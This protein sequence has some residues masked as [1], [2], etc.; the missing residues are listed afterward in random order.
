MRN[1]IDVVDNANRAVFGN[2]LDP[3]GVENGQDGIESGGVRA[4]STLPPFQSL[5]GCPVQAR[6]LGKVFGGPTQKRTCRT[7]LGRSNHTVYQYV[8]I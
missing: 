7:N 3:N 8:T 4:D 6:P 5:D 2:E 1:S